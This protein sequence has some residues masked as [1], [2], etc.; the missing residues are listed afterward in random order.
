MDPWLEEDRVW[1]QNQLRGSS[2]LTFAGGAGMI[3]GVAALA[4]WIALSLLQEGK[5]SGHSIVHLSL[6]RP[7]PLPAPPPP[8]ER[9]PEPEVKREIPAPQPKPREAPKV[10]KPDNPPAAQT[11]LDT[12]R[13]GS[14]N[15]YALAAKPGG[16]DITIGGDVG[17]SRAKFAWFVGQVQNEI[18]SYLQENERLRQVNYRAAVAVWFNLD[19]TVARFQLLGSSGEPAVDR[20]LS[21]AMSAMPRLLQPPPTDLP[22]P[23]KIRITSRGAT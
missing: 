5:S 23:V 15:A 18:Q 2:W 13:S 12:D 10:E 4:I 8:K 11:G 20:E 14:P 17:G 22:Q 21:S 16:D 9:P 1:S 19:G 6:L 3:A 7:P